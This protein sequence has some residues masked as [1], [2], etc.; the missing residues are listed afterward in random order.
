LT[1]ELKPLMMALAAF[2]RTA[3]SPGTAAWVF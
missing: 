1:F 3:D 2:F